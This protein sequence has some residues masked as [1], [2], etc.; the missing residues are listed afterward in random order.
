[1]PVVRAGIS[2]LSGTSGRA[3]RAIADRL[4]I[5]L[6]TGQE[7]GGI[8]AR[9][10]D[11]SKIVPGSGA[12]R[13]AST[14]NSQ[15]AGA[16][17]REAGIPGSTTRLT[18]DVLNTAEGRIGTNIENAARRIDI[19]GGGPPGSAGDVLLNEL[20]N[21]ESAARLAGD[22]TPHATAVRNM[23]DHI[24]TIMSNSGQVLPGAEFQNLIRQGGMLERATRS[25]TAE[26]RDAAS[27]IRRALFDAAEASNSPAAA[28]LREAR[29]QYKVVQTVRDAIDKTAAGSEDM[30][31][32]KL[33]Q[34]IRNNFDMTRT[35]A[36][37]NMQDLARLLQ[38]TRPL[39]S[40]GTAERL[41]MYGALGLGGGGG[42]YYYMQ[43]PEETENFLLQNAPLAAAG[44]LA[45]RASRLGPGLGLRGSQ[46]FDPVLPRVAGP[47]YRP[48]P[49][50]NALGQP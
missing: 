46:L 11:V 32:A 27:G 4:G 30:S 48:P 29:Y 2:A 49:S 5:E 44:I 28:A 33:A 45:G 36:G 50:E 13:A 3:L 35:G 6:T 17:A 1:M 10:E 25:G 26:I 34:L 7:V 40:S 38:G 21:I 9:V 22:T 43:H 16:I 31:H 42:A 24:T 8:A 12:G 23:I 39:A 14:Q 37:N 15:I 41:A 19:P 47:L 20:G 18:T